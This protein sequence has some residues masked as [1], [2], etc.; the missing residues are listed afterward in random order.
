D[1]L[2]VRR[3]R[4][5]PELSTAAVVNCVDDPARAGSWVC[6]ADPAEIGRVFDLEIVQGH[7]A[8]V[9]AGGIGVVADRG[10]PLGALLTIG[11]A[12]FTVKAVYR[13]SGNFSAY[14]MMPGDLARIGGQP[15]PGAAYLRVA[16]GVNPAAA[17]AA[18]ERAVAGFP[19]VEVH[20]RDEFHLRDLD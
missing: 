19:A 2:M 7:F 9:T 5:L 12:T 10:Y 6:G 14:L 15:F 1:P 13:S 16:P 17:R 20:N 8:D 11:A 18:V 4:A 3:L